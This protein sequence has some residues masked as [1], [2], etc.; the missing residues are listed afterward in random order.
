MVNTILI[1]AVASLCGAEALSSVASSFAEASF[2]PRNVAQNSAKQNWRRARYGT[3]NGGLKWVPKKKAEETTSTTVQSTGKDDKWEPENALELVGDG[4]L[5]STTAPSGAS[6]SSPGSGASDGSFEEAQREAKRAGRGK[7]QR[8]R[9]QRSKRKW[10][11]NVEER[12]RRS[13]AAPATAT[14][15]AAAAVDQ[16]TSILSS[17]ASPAPQVKRINTLVRAQTLVFIFKF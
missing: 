16:A 13:A 17:E 4:D 5:G 3:Q 11:R 15:A 8:E 12:E 2:Q 9:R 14:A 7:R 10:E 1:A 6:G